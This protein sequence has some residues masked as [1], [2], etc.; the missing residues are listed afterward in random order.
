[1]EFFEVIQKRYTH[2]ALFAK[3]AVPDEDL[4]RIVQ[5]GMSAPSAG[6]SQSPEFVIVT[7]PQLVAK[8]GEI[9]GNKIIAS[10]P[11]LIAVLTRPRSREV[12]DT[13]TE[14]LI[15]DWALAMGYMTLA[16]T[17][18]GYCY[19][20]LD[21]P[22]VPEGP[23][24]EAEALLG[25]P[26]DRMLVVVLPVGHPAEPGPRRPKRPFEQRASWNRYEIV[27]EAS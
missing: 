14:C 4:R 25:V 27:R 5:A 10:A 26:A 1:M 11:C 6:N 8:L 19:A 18:L 22:F 2:K 24:H 17:A 9:T 16:A 20:W 12:L 23:R 7:D 15:A 3:D 21:G 13:S